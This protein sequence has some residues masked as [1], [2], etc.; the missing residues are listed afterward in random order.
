[1]NHDIRCIPHVFDANIST[2]GRADIA[3]TEEGNFEVKQAVSQQ[4]DVISAC[5]SA[6]ARLPP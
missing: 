1:M 6:V 2:S 4:V 5:A 3:P